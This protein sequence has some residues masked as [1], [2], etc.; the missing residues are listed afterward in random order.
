MF[1][2][3]YRA[4]GL[5]PD[6]ALY[7]GLSLKILRGGEYWLLTG[8]GNH[9]AEFF[10]HPPYF[11]QWGSGVLKVL[12]T[13]DGAARAIGGLP[14][15]LALAGL[16][17]WLMWKKS[18]RLAVI[19]VVMA[20]TWTHYT[21]FAASALLEAPL[22]LGVALVFVASFEKFYSV[23]VGKKNIFWTLLLIAGLMLATAAKGV[24]GF[25]AWGAL[26]L[27]FFC[28]FIFSPRSSLKLAVFLPLLFLYFLVASLPL[29]YWAFELFRH[30]GIEW[31][32][33]YFTEQVLRSAT[34]NRGE[35]THP[36]SG[37][38]LYYLKSLAR[39]A[40]PWLWAFA[41]LYVFCFTKRFAKHSL[42]RQLALHILSFV[43]AFGLPLSFV[44]WQLT[45]YLHPVYLPLLVGGAYFI[46]ELIP[47][48]WN[49]LS[50]RTWL[51]S[52]WLLF[53]LLGSLSFIFVKGPTKVPNRGQEFREV[54]AQIN[55]L[56]ETCTVHIAPETMDS[57]RAEAYALWYWQGRAWKFSPSNLY[58]RIAVYFGSVYWDP[59]KKELWSSDA[60]PLSKN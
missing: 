53:I 59:K 38:R 4:Q 21:K 46:D 2:A 32:I 1:F 13:S 36:L 19:F 58:S 24:M 10:E 51:L 27:A 6:A 60:C 20:A 40:W 31:I 11:F 55:A 35:D 26:V 33:R 54:A 28:A 56:P 22:A 45:H 14:S 44:S 52:R 41:G 3:F 57:Y 47:A 18:F 12:G 16:A 34:S 49:R 50:A 29:V 42:G 8:S 43:L 5:S 23:K 15:W 48:R 37:D 30:N 9:F 25:G 17:W 39:N 7:A